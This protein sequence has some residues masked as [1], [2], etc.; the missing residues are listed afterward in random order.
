MPLSNFS[1]MLCVRLEG[2][3]LNRFFRQNWSKATT[4]ESGK[5]FRVESQVAAKR[6]GLYEAAL[7]SQ[8][9]RNSLGAKS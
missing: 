1:E 8:R 3:G 9:Y 6:R 2:V 7:F 5:I 4:N